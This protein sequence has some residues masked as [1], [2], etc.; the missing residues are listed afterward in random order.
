[1]VNYEILLN[2]SKGII[3]P[4][5]S[6]LFSANQRIRAAVSLIYLIIITFLSLMPA[7]DVPEIVFFNGIDKLVHFCMY[8]G[9][10][11]LICW[12]LHSD[13]KK[14][15]SY[16]VIILTICLGA[17]LELFQLVMHYGRSFEWLDILANSIGAIGGVLIYNLMI[18][19]MKQHTTM[20]KAR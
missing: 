8:L 6:F 18:L 4:V 5:R 16:I 12:S 9:L 17:V 15:D 19:R 2:N 3:Y 7:D 14:S 11:W 13:K 10:T 20:S 1:L